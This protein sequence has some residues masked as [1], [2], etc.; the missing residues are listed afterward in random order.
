MFSLFF[1]HPVL[2]TQL[3][4]LT[5]TYVNKQLRGKGDFSDVEQSQTM[6]VRL[7][8]KDAPEPMKSVS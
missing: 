6:N 7:Y 8:A 5:L 3:E 4:Q 1:M 2:R